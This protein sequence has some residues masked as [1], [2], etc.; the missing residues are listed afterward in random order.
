[1]CRNKRVLVAVMAKKESRRLPNKNLLPF[2]H[3]PLFLWAVIYAQKEG[4]TPTVFTDDTEGPI[5][6]LAKAYGAEVEKEEGGELI[7]YSAIRRRIEEVGEEIIAVLQP[8]TPIRQEGRLRELIGRVE[9]GEAS[10][11]YTCEEV[12]VCGH[13]DGKY[14]QAITISPENTLHRHDGNIVTCTSEFFLTHNYFMGDTGLYLPQDFPYTIDI[15]TLSQFQLAEH[16]IHLLPKADSEIEKYKQIRKSMG[17]KYVIGGDI[18]RRH[19]KDLLIPETGDIYLP[20][21]KISEMGSN[22]MRCTTHSGKQIKLK[23]QG[24]NNWEMQELAA[25]AD[26]QQERITLNLV[27]KSAH[28]ED[29]IY[30]DEDTM[31]GSRNSK[32][33]RFTVTDWKEGEKITLIWDI[34]GT[35]TFTYR[36]SE[37]GYVNG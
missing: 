12:K 17:E 11:I 28:W 22:G 25:G 18:Y 7:S 19:E 27:N 34:W 32:I 3:L 21:Y 26:K 35:E 5:G 23:K 6:N 36:K 31:R 15:D 29:V 37:G 16:Y 14:R 8:T 9:R 24:G 30:F 1:M 33:D 2:N 10:S 13:L 4:Y 20:I